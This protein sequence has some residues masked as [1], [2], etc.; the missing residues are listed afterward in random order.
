MDPLFRCRTIC[1]WNEFGFITLPPIEFLYRIHPEYVLHPTPTGEGFALGNSIVFLAL[2]R[3]FSLHAFV[4]PMTEIYHYPYLCAGWFGLFV[5]SLNLIPIGQLDGG[6]ILFAMLGRK[7]QLYTARV[8]VVFLVLAGLVGV[9]PLIVPSTNWGT[10][11][12]LLWAAILF[13]VIKLEHPPIPIREA[14]SWRRSVLGWFA[15]L[16]FVTTF[17]PVPFFG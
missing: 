13:F 10:L 11:G 6:H 17:P 4:P 14:L 16:L 12:W 9:V 3:L 5:T 15:I 8:F 1:E 7:F 2:S